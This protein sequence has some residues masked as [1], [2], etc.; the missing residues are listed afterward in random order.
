MKHSV[1]RP[2]D[3]VH[4]FFAARTKKIMAAL[5]EPHLI[6]QLSDFLGPQ[7]RENRFTLATTLWLGIYGAAKAAMD[8]MSQILDKATAALEGDTCQP[9]RRRTLTPSGWSRAKSRMPLNLLTRLWRHFVEVAQYQAGET[10]LFH[11]MRL[12]ALDKKTIRVPEAL[13]LRFGSH[14]GGRGDGPAQAELIVPYDVIARVPLD[15][16]LA[17]AKTSEAALAGPVLQRLREPSLVLI[18]I[19]FYGI[20]MFWT[21]LQSGHHFVTRM[22]TSGRPRLIRKLGTGDGIYEIE[23][24]GSFRAEEH[25]GVPR[26]MTVRIVRAQWKGFRPIRL[27]TSLLDPEEYPREDFLHLYHERW[28]IETFFRELSSDVEFEHWH[29]RTEHGLYV[30]LLF[31]MIYVSL[32]RGKMAEG[33][34][35]AAVLPG[36]LSFTHGRE[37]CML[38]WCRM[39]KSGVRSHEK[40]R[41]ELIEHLGTLIIDVRPG[42]SFE[43]NTQKR[44]AKSRKRQLQAR[45]R[46]R[47]AA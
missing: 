17:K 28:H 23:V 11:G 34:R 3:G 13:W 47:H 25:P 10:A 18:D 20:A 44:R 32:V 46:K 16:V 22:R 24:G 15:L 7:H 31:Q 37:A 6:E 35:E 14:E 45:R 26:K 30:E 39:A 33:A 12:V 38:T 36:D 27:V 42:R 40:L 2:D 4:S 5:M 8:S 19:G 1:A 41:D 21:I 43:R 9:L 29:T